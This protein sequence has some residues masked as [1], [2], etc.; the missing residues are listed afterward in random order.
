MKTLTKFMRNTGILVVILL[1]AIVFNPIV[2]TRAND[3][4]PAPKRWDH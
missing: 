2:V 1:A 4:R 3:F